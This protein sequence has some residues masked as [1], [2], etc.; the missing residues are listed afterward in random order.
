MEPASGFLKRLLGILRSFQ[1]VVEISNL[2]L[3]LEF[4]PEVL[5]EVRAQLRGITGF[6][7]VFRGAAGLLVGPHSLQLFRRSWSKLR[8][9]VILARKVYV[10]VYV[11]VRTQRSAL[12]QLLRFLLSAPPCVSSFLR[13]CLVTFLS[14]SSSSSTR[15]VSSSFFLQS[16]GVSVSLYAS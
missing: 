5:H 12:T 9:C 11:F 6:S 13:S 2:L 7:G 8:L 14:S 10:T 3:L 15:C 4:L 1:E 16:V